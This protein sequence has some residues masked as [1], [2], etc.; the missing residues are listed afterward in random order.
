MVENAA[1]KNHSMLEDER[2]DDVRK[3]KKRFKIKYLDDAY[4][5]VGHV[6]SVMVEEFGIERP[7]INRFIEELNEYIKI[8]GDGFACIHNPLESFYSRTA[9]KLGHYLS[10]KFRKGEISK[11]SFN[12]IMKA[13]IGGCDYSGCLMR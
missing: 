7:D 13:A 8:G 5:P 9:T 4:P 6:Y 11:D 3:I 10:D 1:F 2:L 12:V